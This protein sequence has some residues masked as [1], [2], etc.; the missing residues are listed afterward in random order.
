MSKITNFSAFP[1]TIG[2]VQEN[3]I[4]II[5]TSPHTE[6]IKK[7]LTADNKTASYQIQ[8]LEKQRTWTEEAETQRIADLAEFREDLIREY[9]A[10]LPD[11]SLSVPIGFWY[12][13]SEIDGMLNTEIPT[14]DLPVWLRDYQR[15]DVKALLQYK[16]VLFCLATGLGKTA[17]A[18]AIVLQSIKVKKRTCMIVPTID[19]VAQTIASA[20]HF[21]IENVSGA[22]GDYQYK[23][24]CDLLVTTVQSAYKYI[25]VFD[26]VIVDE[27]QHCSAITWFN[28]L[29]SALK[30]S[31]VYG[32]SA[33][34]YRT[35]GLDL[36]IFAWCGPMVIERSAKWGIE[37]G[38]LAEP[39]IF[40]VK[41]TD[42][43]FIP[44]RKIGAI[45]YGILAT[46]PKVQQFLLEQIQKALSVGRTVMVIFNTVKAGKAFKI[47][48]T[49]KLDFE[50]A[51]AGYRVPFIQ[52]KKGETNLL[53]GN[54]K[55]FGEGVDVPRVSCIA[56]LCNNSS[57]ITT[58]QVLGRAMR[59]S[60]GKKDAIVLDV[61]FD[62]YE[63]YVKSYKSRSKIYK[64][65]VDNVKEIIK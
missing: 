12:L 29:A 54:V 47:Y 53:V 58:R 30:A 27:S 35:D 5:I 33:T 61:G 3:G 36:G 28:L 22:G 41:I 21:G 7:Y 31:H 51:H 34:P 11:G 23:L 13:C 43:P 45:A 16:R 39:K 18:I 50:V 49:G 65:I 59:I 38:W 15:E 40:M 1:D 46:H 26:V 63:P 20:K 48:C 14:N 24:G 4:E 25:D 52:F 44:S 8:R 6:A 60:K 62:S 19:L 37:N 9:F 10:E 56:T 42:L 57:E 17:C 2:V 55:L 64:T 32:L